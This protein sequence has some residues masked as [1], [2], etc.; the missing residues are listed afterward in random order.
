MRRIGLI[1]VVGLMAVSM[2][3]CIAPAR[4]V[5]GSDGNGW[6]RKP[7]D[8]KTPPATLVARDGTVCTVSAGKFER[9]VLGERVTCFWSG[10]NRP[11]GLTR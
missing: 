6:A 3:G 9:V 8:G 4:Y 7:V 5:M 1:A 2:G 10:G 11:G